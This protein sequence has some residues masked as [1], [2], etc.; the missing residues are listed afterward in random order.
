MQRSAAVLPLIGIIIAS[1]GDDAVAS[2]APTA[3]PTPLATQAGTPA[4][5]S[6]LFISMVIH[7]ANVDVDEKGT[8]AAA[9]TAVIVDTG[10]PGAAAQK[11]ITLRLDRPF[12]FFLREVETGA[13][14]F[15]G[16]VTDPSAGRAQ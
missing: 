6:S 3:P 15:M 12:L 5:T 16:R 14:L 2:I 9:A 11:D 13:V 10:G 4:Q 8:E 7:Q 1:C